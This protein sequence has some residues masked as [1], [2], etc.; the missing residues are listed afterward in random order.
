[1]LKA[2]I[3]SVESSNPFLHLSFLSNMFGKK[4]VNIFPVT[5]IVDFY[6]LLV[7]LDLINYPISF[8]PK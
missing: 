3:K 8:G 1:M 4:C 7:F 5:N 6:D 2:L